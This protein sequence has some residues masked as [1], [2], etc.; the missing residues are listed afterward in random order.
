LAQVVG[1]RYFG[2]YSVREIA[3]TL[4]LTERTVQRD[5]EKV[6]GILRAA[7]K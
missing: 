3:K 1:M 5:W 2:G 4:G 7:L 6:R